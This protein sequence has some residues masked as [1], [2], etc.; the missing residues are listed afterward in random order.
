MQ[1]TTTCAQH[2]DVP[3][4]ETCERCGRPVCGG[5]VIRDLGTERAYCSPECYAQTPS[6]PGHA[7]VANDLYLEGLQSPL[8]VGWKLWFRSLGRLSANVFPAAIAFG[9]L[10]PPVFRALDALPA[11]SFGAADFG[12]WGL[13]GLWLVGASVVGLTMSQRYT[14]HVEGHAWMLAARRFFP[15]LATWLLMLALVLVGYIALILPGIYL[16]LR[17]FWAD[18]FALVHGKNPIAALRASWDLTRGVAGPVFRFQF[19]N[20][21]ASYLFLIPAFVVIVL[22]VGV[23]LPEDRAV[24]P[25]A[26]FA[27]GFLVTFIGL[28]TYG[29]LHGPELAWF[30]GVRA[31]HA[32]LSPEQVRRGGWV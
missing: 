6:V 2:P 18:E 12:F 8:R 15:L 23:L 16:A 20:G 25:A 10:A 27:V 17:F 21:L 1:T 29:A 26:G 24:H 28:M 3:A 4:L 22:S 9:L 31:K 7:P 14:N 5:C 19:V 13:M 11:D 30:Y 32:T